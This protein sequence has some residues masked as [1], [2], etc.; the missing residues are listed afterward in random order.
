MNIAV[1]SGKG[2]TGKTTVAVN[3]ARVLHCRYVDSDVEAP[4][5]FLF[6]QPD[7]QDKADVSVQIPQID[8][9][10]CNY[11][12][13]CVKHCQ[14]NALFGTDSSIVFFEKLCHSCG[15]CS[16]VCKQNAIKEVPRRVGYVEFG[17]SA[18]AECWQGVLIPGEPV[19][20]PVIDALKARLDGDLSII[21]CPPGSSCSV[22]AAADKTDLALLV[23]EPTP[24]GVHDLHMAVQVTEKLNLPRAIIINRSEGQDAIIQDYAN[25]TGIPIIGRLPFSLEAAQIVSQG[26][27]LV[28]KEEWRQ[29][30]Q[31]LAEAVRELIA[32]TS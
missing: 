12:L 29:R 16:L 2:G 31:N 17:S 21:D 6:L 4:N 24:F 11:C 27:L 7:I 32:C 23:T 13:A 18:G 28:D 10:R 3:L 1:L 20:G 22:V 14:F 15:L 5:G 8:E 25:A 19:T 9:Q 30:F 26:E